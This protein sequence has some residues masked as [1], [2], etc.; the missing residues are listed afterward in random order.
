MH[1]STGIFWEEVEV[2]IDHIVQQVEMYI[3]QVEEKVVGEVEL[4]IQL[5]DAPR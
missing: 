3:R 5:Q 2:E 4:R 1:E